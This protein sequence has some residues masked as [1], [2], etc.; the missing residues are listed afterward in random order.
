M[1]ISSYMDGTLIQNIAAEIIAKVKLGD[2]EKLV[3]N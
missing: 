2:I 3:N 1:D